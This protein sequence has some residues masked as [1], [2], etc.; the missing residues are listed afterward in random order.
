MTKIKTL[1]WNRDRYG[2]PVAK[3]LSQRKFQQKIVKSGK[4]YKRVSKHE[5][6]IKTNEEN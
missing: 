4:E 6:E 2:N 1:K 3:T 5:I